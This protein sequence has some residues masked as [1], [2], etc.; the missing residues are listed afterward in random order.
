VREA[1][2]QERPDRFRRVRRRSMPT[3]AMASIAFS[4]TGVGSMPAH[5]TSKRSPARC[6][7]NPSGG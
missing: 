6:R 2:P 4:F 7:R 1:L 5:T 3:S